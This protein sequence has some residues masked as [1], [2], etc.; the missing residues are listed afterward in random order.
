MP[1]EH[2]AGL[3]RRRTPVRA[4]VGSAEILG[5]L[6]I[7]DGI[8]AGSEIRARLHLREPVVAFPGVRFILRRPSPM[9]LLGGGYVE[10]VDLRPSVDGRTVDEEAIL[11]TLRD[12]G[13]EG[14]ELSTIASEA[15]LRDDVARNAVERLIERDEVVR[16]GRPQAYI[17]G[18]AARTL[19][20]SML[21]RLDEAH[22]IEPWA[23]GM[24]SI[25]LSRALGVPETTLV[26]VAGH[27]LEEGR[28]VHRGG[29]YAAV[30]HRPTCTPEQRAFF[31]QLVPIGASQPFL[32][33]PFA[34]AAAA[35]KASPIGGI[36]KSF[37]TMLAL[38]A[39][40]KIGDD[41]YQGL[42]IARIRARVEAYLRE[43]NRMTAAEF[44]DILGTSRKYA[45][46]LL[47]WL[48]SHAVTIR[49]GDYRT[50]RQ[51]KSPVHIGGPL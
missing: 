27:F 25:A 28:V 4:Y 8:T 6:A 13:L 10:G 38:G 31:E 26:R 36:G 47:E 51:A 46:P 41:L 32:P 48:D 35:V 39:L 17:E 16:V 20:A 19:L 18:G 21:A 22:R 12:K 43:H 50:L 30:D 14:V 37:D 33:A 29:Y 2:T 23:M 11:A 42:Q 45:V 7:D 24:T 1:L 5:T 49:N 15:N 3:L 40:V 44:R 9:T 34:A